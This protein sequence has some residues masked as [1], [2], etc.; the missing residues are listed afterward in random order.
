MRI[1]LLAAE[2]PGG[3]HGVWYQAHGRAV[4]TVGSS[5]F[6]HFL[7]RCLPQLFDHSNVAFPGYHRFDCPATGLLHRDSGAGPQT[8]SARGGRGVASHQ[9]AGATG[10]G[11]R[12]VAAA[13]EAG[14]ADAPHGVGLRVFHLV[15]GPFGRA[16]GPGHRPALQRGSVAA[17]AASGRVL[18]STSQA[19]PQRQARREGLPKGPGAVDAL[20]KRR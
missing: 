20:K 15:H 6:L 7:G 2:P 4:G 3:R 14:S 8:L 16:F 1:L 13:D 19:H 10:K 9:A 12:G 5:S 18:G 17:S 11:Y